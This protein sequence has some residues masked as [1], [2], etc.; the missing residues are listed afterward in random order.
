MFFYEVAIIKLKLKPLVFASDQL[1]TAGALVHINF[2]KKPDVLH[3]AIILRQVSQPDFACTPI[4]VITDQS[5]PEIYLQT[6]KFI[7]EYYVCEIGEALTLFFAAKPAPISPITI[8]TNIVLSTDQQQ[9]LDFV[10]EPR[11]S[12][13][14]GDTGSGK[15]EIY[16][17]LFEEVLNTGKTALFLMP[18]IS[19][20]PQIQSRLQEHFGDMIALWHSKISPSKKASVLQMI[21]EG[22]IRIVAGARSALFLPMPNLGAIV[23]DE[24]HDDSYKSAARPRYNARDA[25][26]VLGSKLQIPVV[27]GSATPSANSYARFP[28][29]R[30]K[31]G[32]F[33]ASKRSY[34]FVQ[35]A[36]EE[37]CGAVL[38]EIGTT[39]ERGK[40]GIVFLPTRANFKYLVCLDCGASVTC[41]FCEVGMSVHSYKNALQ[42]HYCNMLLPIAAECP[43]CHSANLS[44][45]R[46][47]TAEITALLREALPNARI[48]QF[49]RDTITTDHAL[50]KVLEQ[51]N[52]HEIDLLVGTQMLSKGHNYH[53]VELC[54]AL[55]F[56]RLLASS[57]YRAYERS[58][59]L[60]VQLSGRSGRKSSAKVIIQTLNRA[61]FEPFLNDYD[62]FVQQEITAREGLYPP[63]RRLLRV[64]IS[65]TNREKAEA[66][67]HEIL[68]RI[69]P[70][71][72]VQTVG[73][74]E[75]AISRIKT[76][77]R[78][79][80]LLRSLSHRALITAAHAAD[81][82]NAEIEMDP[83]NFA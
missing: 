76:K 19:L 48:T 62:S 41:P 24:E 60:L 36:S 30:L 40:Q 15:S 51:F 43:A 45:S 34:I 63:H 6:A 52:N 80:I 38:D 20:T 57:D 77:Y 35:S 64:L 61:A 3:R 70:F 2:A 12:L 4:A 78:Y 71:S 26:C 10:R 29:F 42:C 81:M 68:R 73:S 22:K 67:M 69:A 28:H 74:G 5:L 17:K 56:D 7:A 55:G 14:F 58:M 8:S 31:G 83:V 13:L 53:G 27:L 44:A 49:D 11:A 32:Y 1:I 65:D 54:V 18:E 82:P 25:A 47:G 59:S 39:I 9:A 33:S 37:P 79:Y 75:C 66:V 50:R 23:V 21:S 46:H 72:E 16:M